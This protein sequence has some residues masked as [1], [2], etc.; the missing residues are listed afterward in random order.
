MDAIVTA[1]GIPLP[2]EPL[3]SETKGHNKALLEVAGKPMVQWVLDA[4][5]A[6][7]TIDNVIV[8]GLT[9]KAGL[10]C[11]KPVHYI[12]NQGRM[13]DNFRAGVRKSL[14]LGKKGKHVLFVSADIPAINGEMVD[15]VVNTAMKTD[16]DIYY[17]VIQ[18]EVM[19]KRF[20]ESK[21]TYTRLKGMEVCGGDMNVARAKLVVAE[22]ESGLWEKI[23]NSRKSP[24]KQA[25]LIGFDTLFLLLFRQLTLEMA[26]EKIT[27]KLN[28]TGQVI[29]CPY[30]EV[31][32]DVDKPHQLEII[33]KDFKKRL[34]K[35]E[36]LSGGKTKVKSKGK[37]P[38]VK[39]LAAKK[40]AKK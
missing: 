16:D 9:E 12:S 7:K 3:Y 30:A 18:R 32:M 37:K 36:K 6:A 11:K 5:A 27:K 19:E 29:V 35:D 23:S 34:K 26:A 25:A 28:I 17:N 40:S 22:D 21:R 10:A 1:G 15:W 4:L 24:L 8:V 39:R 20:P 33:R 38:A 2:E 31:G 14:D 13:L